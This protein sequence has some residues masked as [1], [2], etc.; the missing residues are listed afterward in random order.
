[1]TPQIKKKINEH[2]Q[3][4]QGSIQDIARFYRLSVEEVLEAL[5]LSDIGTV[6]I[7]GDLIDAD[8]A[9]PNTHINNQGTI[10]K[11][12]FSLN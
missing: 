12:P 9:G 7:A 4:G 10:H 1:M 2:Y 11:V 8:E 5:N 6:R 3:R